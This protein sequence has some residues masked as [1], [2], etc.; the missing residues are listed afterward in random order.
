MKIIPFF[1]LFLIPAGG[2]GQTFESVVDFSLELS[3]LASPETAAQAAE[4]GRI[5][6][7]EGLMSETDIT[8]ESGEPGVFVTLIGGSWEGTSEV[9]SYSCRV[10]FEGDQWIEVF[11]LSKPDTPPPGYVSPGSRLL[12]AAR[13]TGYDKEAGMSEAVM[14]DF[15]VLE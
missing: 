15:R 7:L 12:I 9:R 14:I 1:L 3:S 13:I 6:I 8:P 11:P 5:V 2:W 10:L 4:D